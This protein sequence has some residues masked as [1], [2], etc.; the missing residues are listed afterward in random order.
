MNYSVK[1][2]E[3]LP[4][5]IWWGI[6]I[7]WYETIIIYLALLLIVFS[8]SLKKTKLLIFSGMT[9]ILI[10]GSFQVKSYNINHTNEIVVYN[11]KDEI[12]IDIYYG[13]KN[14]FLASENL[15]KNEDK[16][17]FHIQH[18]WFYKFGNEGA[19]EFLDINKLS[20]P[21]LRLDNDTYSIF[22]KNVNPTPYSTDYVI[23]GETDYINETTLNKWKADQT[24]LIVHPKCTNN[25]KGYLKKNYP[26]KLQYNI[27]ENGAFIT[28]FSS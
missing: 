2:V 13:N 7:S 21:I 26:K 1:W 22:D 24:T 16:L 5:S 10:L 9:T 18:Y 17:L 25:I 6:S 12:A 3:Q 4:F 15:F 20:S 8:F 23:I 11:V 27:S 19:Y 28:S 14:L